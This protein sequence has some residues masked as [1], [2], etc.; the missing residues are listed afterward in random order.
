MK[1]LRWIL[2]GECGEKNYR[3]TYNF[4]HRRKYCNPPPPHPPLPGLPRM[5]VGRM[6]KKW[7]PWDMRMYSVQPYQSSP[8]R[9]YPWIICCS[10]SIPQPIPV[11]GSIS[12]ETKSGPLL[13]AAV[14]CIH[15]FSTQSRRFPR[16]R[17]GFCLSTFSKTKNSAYR[18]VSPHPPT[19]H[20]NSGGWCE[21]FNF[22]G[23]FSVCAPPPPPPVRYAPPSYRTRAIT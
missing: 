20:F 17:A 19:R 14:E 15:Q 11:G 13:M 12:W 8:A 21:M 2:G 4:L 3:L 18:L 22:F 10:P 16:T 5:S 9:F 23:I 6:G 7:G 1:K